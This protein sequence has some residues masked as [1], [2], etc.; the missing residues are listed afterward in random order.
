MPTYTYNI[1]VYGS[2]SRHTLSNGLLQKQTRSVCL[3]LYHTHLLY[4]MLCVCM[5]TYVYIH[6]YVY[7]VDIISSQAHTH[8][9]MVHCT[10]V[11]SHDSYI[12]TRAHAHTHTMLGF[13]WYIHITSYISFYTRLIPTFLSNLFINWCTIWELRLSVCE[14]KM[15]RD[16]G[17]SWNWT[18][19]VRVCHIWGVRVCQTYGV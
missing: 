11:D 17:W 8:T 4:Y 7:L 6:V 16:L 13:M 5:Y 1:H 9:H 18:L 3:A 14:L 12:Y 10:R 15:L 2:Q 19:G